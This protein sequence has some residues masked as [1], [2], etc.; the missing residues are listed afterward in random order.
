[1]SD[2]IA[3][4]LGESAAA[5]NDD[6]AAAAAAA[7]AAAPGGEAAPA[8]DAAKDGDAAPWF[9]TLAISAEAPDDKTL[10]NQAWL[11]NKKYGSP[12][13]LVKAMRGLESKLGVDKIPADATGYEIPVPEGQDP[14]FAGAFAETALK[15]GVPAPMAKGL[16]EWWNGQMAEAASAGEAAQA[17]RDTSERAEL[18]K[19]WGADWGKNYEIISRAADR[20]GFGADEVAGMKATIGV[21]AM[22]E[23]LLAIGKA[24]GED[25]AIGGG[26]RDMGAMTA[27]QASERKAAIMADPDA[28]KK[29]NAK[30]PAAV[31]EWNEIAEAMAA[32]A[33]RRAAA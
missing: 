27:A 8:G 32:E 11:E 2:A 26:K 12:D 1:M 18:K 30:D 16:A 14:A 13:D 25:S 4:A 24:M 9:G 3:A 19:S 28:M 17:A 7:A 22:S 21:K 23:R 20:F 10:S 5:A 6:P 31:R 15:L 29:I 33:E